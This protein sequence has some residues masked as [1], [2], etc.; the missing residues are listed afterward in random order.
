[1]YFYCFDINR[2]TNIYQSHHK[3]QSGDL[4]FYNHKY[5]L[6]LGENI[7]RPEQWATSIYFDQETV[8]KW[9]CTTQT[10]KLLHWMV[11]EW[12]SS[13]NKCIP[14]FFWNDINL[15]LRHKKTT[16]SNKRSEEPQSLIIFPSFFSLIQYHNHHD[17]E[18]I[19]TLTGQSTDI[20]R[21]KAYR[22]LHN[23]ESKI[24]YATHSQI[25]QDRYN[26]TS[27]TVID[28]YSPQYQT[29]QEPRYN[30]NAVIEKIKEIYSIK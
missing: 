9:L 8:I 6:N 1:L 26:L 28:E 18:Q 22:S 11:N 29:Y 12:F 2:T 16:T 25:F 13:Y 17:D 15:L 24:L 20:A 19:I 4:I 21:S 7:S 10:V 3:S 23:N 30:I 14:L 5:Y 27:I